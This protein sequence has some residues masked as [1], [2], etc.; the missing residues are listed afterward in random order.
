MLSPGDRRHR[1]DLELAA[2]LIHRR[3]AENA[4]KKKTI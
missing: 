1:A 4:E 2:G 3:D